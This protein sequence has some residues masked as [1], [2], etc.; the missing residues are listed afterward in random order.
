MSQVGVALIGPGM[1]G[2]KLAAAVRQTPSLRLATCFSRSETQGQAFAAEA[3]CEAAP[4]FEAA[5]EH[6]EVQG[7]LLVTPNQVHAEQAAACARRGKHVFVEKPIADTL[8]DGRAIEAACRT[9]GVV[10]LV[11]HAFR[12]LGAARKVKELLDSG[13]LGKVVLAEANFS[14]PGS[15]TPDKWRFYR[16]TCPGGPLLQLGIH[17]ADTLQY[18]LGPIRRVQGSFARLV[19]PAE[20]DDVG[21]VLLEFESGARGVLSSSY[22]SPK[23]FYLRLYGSEANLLYETDMSIWPKAEQMDAATRLTL[24][25]KSGEEIVSFEPRDMLVE[26]L[27]EFA[28]CIRGEGSPETGAEAA[29]A[30]LRVIQGAITSHQHGQIIPIAD[31]NIAVS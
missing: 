7:V 21:T 13:S 6:P 27:E 1:W 18:W 17:H 14:L 15:L 9:A 8:A 31:E 10:L 2:K 20:I 22:V 29:L 24:Q 26:E 12:R 3:G 19:T 23:T 30:A 25:T 4:S 11:G 16:E 5:V 28:R